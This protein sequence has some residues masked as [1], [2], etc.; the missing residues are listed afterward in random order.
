MTTYHRDYHIQAPAT[1]PI[2]D[3][4]SSTAV[5]RRYKTVSFKSDAAT[6]L[7]AAYDLQGM[8]FSE[9]DWASCA[10]CADLIDRDKWELLA[11]RGAR[12]Y[13]KKHPEMKG[14]IPK[15]VLKARLMELHEE[16]KKARL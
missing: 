5:D 14:L 3:F 13:F 7:M 4:C 8:G 12:T 6:K 2:C 9:G 10:T 11:E 16:F 1:G 15:K